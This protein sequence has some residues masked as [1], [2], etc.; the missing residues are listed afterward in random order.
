M[1]PTPDRLRLV[2]PRLPDDV[3]QRLIEQCDELRD[4]GASRKELSRVA[5]FGITEAGLR[6]TVALVRELTNLGAND[7]IARDLEA[8][9]YTHLDVYKRQREF[10]AFAFKIGRL[11]QMVDWMPKSYGA[12]RE[13]DHCSEIWL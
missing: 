3:R 1:E 2:K 5:A 8:V 9:S 12:Y 13:C 7:A 6:P 11:P 4:K 10:W